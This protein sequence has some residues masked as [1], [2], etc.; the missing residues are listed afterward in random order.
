MRLES[1]NGNEA[2]SPPLHGTS[3][4]SCDRGL[5]M[6]LTPCMHSF[7]ILTRNLIFLRETVSVLLRW[8][9]SLPGVAMTT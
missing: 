5:G 6:R 7:V 4:K 8:S 2:R 1:G 3:N 9:A